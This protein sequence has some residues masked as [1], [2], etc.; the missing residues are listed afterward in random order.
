MKKLSIIGVSALLLGA[1]SF[2]ATS[3][4]ST[5]YRQYTDFSGNVST[6]MIGSFISTTDNP[7]DGGSY[8]TILRNNDSS[9]HSPT[10]NI[11]IYRH[12]NGHVSSYA[13]FD[14]GGTSIPA[15]DSLYCEASNHGP[16]GS[17]YISG[18]NGN[19]NWQAGVQYDVYNDAALGTNVS[20]AA[21][22]SA[23][24]FYGELTDNSGASVS[25]EPGLSNYTDHGISTS[26]QAIYCA[27][28]LGSTTGILDGI[29]R[30]F[31]LGVCN[32]TVFL[33]VPS[34]NA[35]AQF[36]SLASTTQQKIPFS[37]YFDVTGIVSGQSAS[38]SQNLPTY[39]IDLAA[40]DFG[41]SSGLSILPAHLDFLSTST[42]NRFLPAGMHTLLYNLMIFAIWVE[43][44]WLLYGRIVP[45]KAKI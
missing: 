24:S 2:P 43:V 1:F 34:G 10:M 33:F 32:A 12:D 40:A 17:P 29:G 5:L 31:G 35:V 23:T 22:Y 19:T 36:Q 39:G 26:S 3:F 7:I 42:V 28:N 41:S 6:G 14:C 38:S 18:L 37:Y 13:G 16:S 8:V 44:M 21:N 4:A 25:I 9:P 11:R 20:I 30:Q 45:H 15:G 27:D